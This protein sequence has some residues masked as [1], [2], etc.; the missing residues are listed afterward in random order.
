[1]NQAVQDFA[2]FYTTM[3]F[4]LSKGEINYEN[5][6]FLLK[7]KSD[8]MILLHLKREYLEGL[9]FQHKCS[10]GEKMEYKWA[11]YMAFLNT[12][13]LL[14]DCYTLQ[15]LNIAY[16]DISEVTTKD[17]MVVTLIQNGTIKGLS[18]KYGGKIKPYKTLEN[19]VEL[20]VD[21]FDKIHTTL[22]SCS[23]DYTK[24]Q[25]LSDLEKSLS[26]YK[27]LNFS[28]SLVLSWFVIERFI[29]DL[30]EGY[31]KKQS[32]TYNSGLKRINSDRKKS[33]TRQLGMEKK[34]NLLE[35]TDTID[36]ET[37][38][39]LDKLRDIR[40]KVTHGKSRFVCRGEHC[41]SAF[42]M[43]RYFLAKEY[44]ID[45]V[46]NTGYSIMGIYDRQ[47]LGT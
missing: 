25:V 7:I 40:N 30:W 24:I 36:F 47:T 8:G 17:A 26:E 33:L 11:Y 1:M 41:Q 22:D 16:F 21:V 46:L 27:V 28:T 14:L 42:K 4:K 32:I 29:S 15:R 3:P 38:S 6:R 18:Y 45:L 34:L 20:P 39:M 9:H 35:L 2:A 10:T 5:D 43:V 13:Y 19:V 31:L 23:T 12:T 44:H 37:F